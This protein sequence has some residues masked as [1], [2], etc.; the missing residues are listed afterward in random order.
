MNAAGHC[1]SFRKCHHPVF[2]VAFIVSVR[3]CS[4]PKRSMDSMILSQLTLLKA[5]RTSRV[6]KMQ[7][8]LFFL[9]LV[10]TFT[11]LMT[12]VIASMVLFS[13][14]KPNCLG[15]SPP[16]SPRSP[17]SLYQI[18]SGSGYHILPSVL[19]RQ[20]VLYV[21]SAFGFLRGYSMRNSLIS[22]YSEGNLLSAMMLFA[23]YKKDSFS[24]S[25]AT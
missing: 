6:V 8:L 1:M 20:K 19:S 13:F 17:F 24:L 9:G 7:K 12:S 23:K 4:I 16:L 15:N 21:G 22:L 11:R 25:T 14:L 5:F 10:P 18:I 3:Y 2:K